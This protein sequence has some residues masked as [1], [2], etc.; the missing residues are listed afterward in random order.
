MQQ[1]REASFTGLAQKVGQLL[2]DFFLSG[3]WKSGRR[4]FGQGHAAVLLV[5]TISIYYVMW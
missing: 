3:L 4:L 5:E 1:G 2:I